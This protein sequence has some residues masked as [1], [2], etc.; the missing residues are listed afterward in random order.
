MCYPMDGLGALQQRGIDLTDAI[1]G[2]ASQ[3]SP[4][5][6]WCSSASPTSSSAAGTPRYYGRAALNII[7]ID[8]CQ[9]GLLQQLLS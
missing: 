1:G 3:S 4:C 2:W 7:L 8:R 6:S 9:T 5:T